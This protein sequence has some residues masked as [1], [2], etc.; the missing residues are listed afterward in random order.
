MN[1]DPEYGVGNCLPYKDCSPRNSPWY[2]KRIRDKGNGGRTCFIRVIY[3]LHFE[4]V[5]SDTPE[6][7]AVGRLANSCIDGVKSRHTRN[8]PNPIKM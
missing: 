3:S 8:G 4:V 1:G 5:Y 6:L 7:D 2:C